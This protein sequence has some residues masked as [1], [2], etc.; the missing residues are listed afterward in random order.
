VDSTSE[1]SGQVEAI[2][3][4][5]SE[6]SQK[7]DSVNDII[8]KIREQNQNIAQE[9][10]QQSQTAREVSK[11]VQEAAR[12]SGEVAKDAENLNQGVK[13]IASASTDSSKAT[14][15]IIND[16]KTITTVGEAIRVSSDE[17]ATQ[18]TEIAGEVGRLREMLKEFKLLSKMS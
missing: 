3:R 17:V 7:L 6:A 10:E 9:T 14:E 4:A 2:Q 12:T 8:I 5:A 13:K 11:T 16:V 18:S 1:I 15:G